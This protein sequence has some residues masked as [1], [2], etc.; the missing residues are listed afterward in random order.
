M[1]GVFYEK[2]HGKSWYLFFGVSL[3]L[4]RYIALGSSEAAAGS[5]K[6]RVSPRAESS[7][8]VGCRCGRSG[9]RAL[10]SFCSGFVWFLLL[11]FFRQL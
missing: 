4:V 1:D 6:L 9:C 11:L 7:V 5:C 2:N 10:R 8:F 3:F